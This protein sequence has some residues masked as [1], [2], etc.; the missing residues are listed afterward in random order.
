MEEN[1]EEYKF[2]PKCFEKDLNQIFKYLK[3]N[4]K[5][6]TLIKGNSNNRIY[7]INN[8]NSLAYLVIYYII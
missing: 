8:K 2:T 6:K 5:K 7:E 3:F 1:F 4:K